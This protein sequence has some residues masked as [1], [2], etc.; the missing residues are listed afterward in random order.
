MKRIKIAS[1]V[2]VLAFALAVITGCAP[3]AKPAEAPQTPA[4]AP[5][6]KHRPRS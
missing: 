4:E 5:Q 2:L 3:A 1:I 6:Q